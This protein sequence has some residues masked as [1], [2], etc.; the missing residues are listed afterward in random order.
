MKNSFPKKNSKSRV[1]F[2][3]PYGAYGKKPHARINM[4]L[5]SF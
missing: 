1:V 5:E 2:F 3:G 4:R